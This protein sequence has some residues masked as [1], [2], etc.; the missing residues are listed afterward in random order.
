MN[1]YYFKFREAIIEMKASSI[2]L[3]VLQFLNEYYQDQD[4]ELDFEF[5][6]KNYNSLSKNYGFD[7]KEL[8]DD[9]LS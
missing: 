6:G 1:S 5:L 8:F 7:L 4:E 2:R 9:V 3:A